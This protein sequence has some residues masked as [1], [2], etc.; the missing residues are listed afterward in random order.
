MMPI[1]NQR[2]YRLA[3]A[4]EFRLEKA[5]ETAMSIGRLATSLSDAA[6]HAR[7]SAL[8]AEHQ[9]VRAEIDAYENLQNAKHS[10][11]NEAET[12]ELGFVP[13]LARIR[14]RL[15]Q[16][17]LAEML[18]LKEQQIQRYESDRYAGISLKRFEQILR[19]LGVELN[20]RFDDDTA[21]D[22]PQPDRAVEPVTPKIMTEIKRRQWFPEAQDAFLGNVTKEYLKR[23]MQLIGGDEPYYRRSVS[24]N[25]NFD[26]AALAAWQARIAS[27]AQRLRNTLKAKFDFSDMSWLPQLVK[28]SRHDDGP[29][30]APAFLADKGI[31]LIV[32]PH[33]QNTYLDG[34]VFLLPDRTPVI[35]LTLRNDRI[36]NFWFTLLHELG[37]IF[38]HYNR[39]L[40]HGFL[41]DLDVGDHSETEMEADSFARSALIP[42]KIWNTAPARFSKSIGLINEFA[43]ACGIHPAVVV[44]RIQRE[45]QDYKA[46]RGVLGQGQVR[47]MFES[48]RS[49]D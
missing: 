2:E 31:I 27:E 47:K 23:G 43:E 12:R 36:D 37:H 41:D 32:E 30:C 8:Q 34:A 11:G 14:R 4:R 33:F 21:P 28:L 22:A 15:S 29:T 10:V 17:Q 38:L 26:A 35:G 5:I 49:E 25:A 1:L 40:D 9:K 18:G 20:A 46:F 3:K 44:G 24:Q 13:I 7:A 16:R 48:P 39:G 6:L 42:D 19:L 45:R